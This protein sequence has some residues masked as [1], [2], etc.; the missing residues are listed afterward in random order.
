MV[1]EAANYGEDHTKQWC[2]LQVESKGDK[3]EIITTKEGVYMVTLNGVRLFTHPKEEVR[4][5]D[6]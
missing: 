4:R 3:L 6:R 1:R 5:K 2:A